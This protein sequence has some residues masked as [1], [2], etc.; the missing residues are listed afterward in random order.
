[1]TLPD[2]HSHANPQQART[3]KISLALRVDFASGTL[4]GEVALDLAQ[5]R[6]GPL[7][8]DTRDL[9]IEAVSTLDGRPLRHR[10]DPR[11]PILG[12]RLRIDLPSHVSGVRIRYATSKSASALQWL[13][14]AR[15]GSG[16][17]PLLY[18]QCQSIHAHPLAPLPDTPA[19]RARL[20]RRLT[21][22]A[23]LPSSLP[24]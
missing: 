1:M 7:D 12:S 11:D 10:L 14:P 9:D 17:H 13:E 16:P 21:V 19:V 23:W 8:L 5:A 24:Q 2:P 4:R 20:G 22:P 3:E 18:S 15:K 6:E